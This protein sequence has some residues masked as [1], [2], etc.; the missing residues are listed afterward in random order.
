M[1]LSLEAASLTVRFGKVSALEAVSVSLP[2]GTHALI[3]GE[4][5]TGKTTLLK[6]LAALQRPTKGLVNWNGQDVWTLSEPQRREKQ[7]L[8][9]FVFQTD[10]LFDSMSVLENVKLPLLRRGVAQAEAEARAR[11]SLEQVGLSAAVGKRPE[12]L[13]GGM[14]KRAGIARAIVARPDVLLA[15]DPFAGLDPDTEAQIAQLL[16]DVAKNRTLIAALPDPV[17]S[18]PLPVALRLEVGRASEA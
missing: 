15:D 16:I 10:A 12:D 7:A 2:F 13:S 1:S 5:A 3:V 11:E 18:L 4:A 8:L 9:G 14:K 17:A 6:A